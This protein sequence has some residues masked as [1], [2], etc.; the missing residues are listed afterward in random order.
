MLINVTLFFHRT[1]FITFF[2]TFS[3][4]QQPFMSLKKILFTVGR[5]FGPVYCQIMRLRT[6]LYNCGFFKQHAFPVPVISVG[7]LTMGGTGKTP[8]VLH[9]AKLLRENGF[10]PAI[11]SRGY[12]GKTTEDINVVS[13]FQDILLTAEV[14]GDE[15]YMLASMLPGVPVITGRKRVL[16]AAYAVNTFACNIL[17]LDDGYQHLAVKRDLNL[18]LFADSIGLGN[19][20]VFPGG[21]LRESTAALKRADLFLLTG[22]NRTD[23]T[24]PSAIETYLKTEWPTKPLLSS[25]REQGSFIAS[26]T[27]K[28]HNI[29]DIPKKIIAFCGIANPER[30]RDDLTEYG[31]EIVSFKS[32]PDHHKYSKDDVTTLLDKARA[33]GAEAIITTDKD[34]VK[35]G[36]DGA[37]EPPIFTVRPTNTF[38]PS[39]D[40]L[41]LSVAT[42][43]QDL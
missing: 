36:I 30:V 42:G 6:L 39:F 33:T 18:A 27:G 9:I 28:S 26:D 3:S 22:Q 25:T 41:I 40:Q 32:Y 31:F 38:A 11:I 4:P 16:T 17:I 20:R 2:V 15:P 24:E 23:I 29:E 21:D 1:N 34:L 8:T 19:G 43:Q 13:D 5:P 7:N 12:G 35:L 37:T 10:R 14:A